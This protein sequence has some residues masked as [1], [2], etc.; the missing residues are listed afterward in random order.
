MTNDFLVVGM[1]TLY[2]WIFA[3]QLHTPGFRRLQSWLRKGWRR[4]LVGCPY[5]F[6]FWA[7]SALTVA[8]QWG[9][10][11]VIATPLSALASAALAGLLGAYFTSG[12][13]EEEA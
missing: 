3:S 6:S 2:V 10:L 13:A 9:R 11:D 4:P 5:C 8:L 7:G 1:S 12:I